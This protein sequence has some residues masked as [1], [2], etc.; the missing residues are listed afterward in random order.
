MTILLVEDDAGV[1][2]MVTDFLTGEGYTVLAVASGEAALETFS[3]RVD[4]VLL[5]LMLPKMSGLSVLKALRQKSVVPVIILTAKG[6]DADKMMGLGLGADDYLTK[7]FSLVELAA[8][9]KAQI[10]RATVYT[11]K[12]AAQPAPLCYRDLLID[13]SRHAVLR[14]GKDLELTRTEYEIVRLLASHPGQA[15]TKEQLYERVWQEPYYGNQNVLTSHINRLRAKL[16]E[17]DYIKTLWGIGY[18]ME[19]EE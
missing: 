13:E 3:E 14:E 18:K 1:R 16:G 2:E 15:F 17:G 6:S 8:R 11:P 4:L 10:R 5:D 19:A 7:P 12:D 9:V